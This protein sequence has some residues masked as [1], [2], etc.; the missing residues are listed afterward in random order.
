M[1]RS[2]R[3]VPYGFQGA[4]RVPSGLEKLRHS[5]VGARETQGLSPALAQVAAHDQ[6]RPALR[7]QTT[8]TVRQ[9]YPP[10]VGAA[11]LTVWTTSSTITSVCTGVR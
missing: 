7:P 8:Q 10:R 1:A 9:W 11:R 3:G 2:L 5:Q 6:P 4:L